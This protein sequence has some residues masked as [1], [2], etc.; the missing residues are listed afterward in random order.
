MKLFS[1]SIATAML[2]VLSSCGPSSTTPDSK[3]SLAGKYPI[4]HFNKGSKTHVVSPYKPH[5]LIDV[6]DIRRGHLARDPST[7]EIDSKTGK[8]IYGTGKIFRI[9]E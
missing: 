9:P 1:L 5:N 6:S 8:P 4:A 3:V 2:A 7:A